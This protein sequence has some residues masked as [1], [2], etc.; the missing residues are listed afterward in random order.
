MPETRRRF[1]REQPHSAVSEGTH[2]GAIE[3]LMI[4]AA[5]DACR[6]ACEALGRPVA[7]SE[8]LLSTMKDL[9]GSIG[10]ALAKEFVARYPY[11]DGTGWPEPLRRLAGLLR[12]R[13]R[14]VPDDDGGDE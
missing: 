4:G 1:D 9:K 7:P 2:A 10:A 8:Q 5:P 14:P 12:A 3:K 11:A 13:L 6:A